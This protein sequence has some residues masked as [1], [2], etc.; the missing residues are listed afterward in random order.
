LFPGE[1]HIEKGEGT[2]S[3][4]LECCIHAENLSDPIVKRVPVRVSIKRTKAFGVAKNQVDF[5]V[6]GISP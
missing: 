3:G 6:A 2:V 1:I 5:L 4:A